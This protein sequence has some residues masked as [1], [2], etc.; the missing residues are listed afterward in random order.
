M[1]PE[2]FD[3]VE[4]GRRIKRL[5]QSQD[6]TVQQLAKRSSVSSGYLSEV[7]RG[8]SAISV[9]KLMQIAEGL[10]IGLDALL[11]ETLAEAEQGTV[12]IPAALSAAAEQLN[13]THR[14]TLLLLKGQR[15][16]TA[17]RSQSEAREWSV[18]DWLKFYEQVK[19]YLSE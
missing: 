8:L 12:Q 7:E 3:R 11:N 16:L 18:D 4:V 10:G 17:R 1:L 2:K 14:V 15:S 6:I 9:D 19:D 13:L 5:R